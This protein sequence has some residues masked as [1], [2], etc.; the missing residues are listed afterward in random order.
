MIPIVPCHIAHVH[1]GDEEF[2]EVQNLFGDVLYWAY[3]R[4][5]CEEYLANAS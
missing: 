5:S 1:D 2:Y 3:D 4:Q